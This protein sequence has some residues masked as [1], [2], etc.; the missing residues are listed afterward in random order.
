[1]SVCLFIC[2]SFRWSLT[3]L[4]K[5]QRYFWLA[6]DS[7]HNTHTW[8]LT[9]RVLTRLVCVCVCVCVPACDWLVG[10]RPSKRFHKIY[11]CAFYANLKRLF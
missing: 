4:Q 5:A 1:M 3:V 9:I 8:E 11:K 2:W 10:F 6:D 7:Y